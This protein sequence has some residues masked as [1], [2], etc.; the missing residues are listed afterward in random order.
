MIV[1]RLDTSHWL[2]LRLHNHRARFTAEDLN[3][4]RDLLALRTDKEGQLKPES[5]SS[6]ETLMV[7]RLAWLL[8]RLEGRASAVG[9]GVSGR[10][11]VGDACAQGVRRPVSPWGSTARS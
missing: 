3:F 4:D 7:S 10:G 2:P 5:P 6:L 9:A 1:H 11:F 8:R